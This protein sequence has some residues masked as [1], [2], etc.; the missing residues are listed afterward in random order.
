ME[1]FKNLYV[2]VNGFN[3]IE[4]NHVED[5]NIDQYS[6]YIDFKYKE[7]INN[8]SITKDISVDLENAKSITIMLK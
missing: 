6:D 2:E 4:A 1:N 3:V 8:A 7:I 5:I